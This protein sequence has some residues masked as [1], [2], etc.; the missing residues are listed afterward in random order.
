MNES[1]RPVPAPVFF[2][3]SSVFFLG[4][5]TPG[6]QDGAV[7][8]KE[9]F[10]ME[11]KFKNISDRAFLVH[12]EMTQRLQNMEQRVAALESLIKTY[13]AEFKHVNAKLADLSAG[14]SSQPTT[15]VTNPSMSIEEAAREVDTQLTR[16]KDGLPPDGVAKALAPLARQAAP[17]ICEALKSSLRDIEYMKKLEYVLARLPAAELKISTE[18]ALK[19]RVARYPVARVVGDVGDKELSRVLEPYTSDAE[20][21]FCYL[22]G[23]SLVRCRNRAGVPALLRALRAEDRNTRFLAIATLRPL[24]N[25]ETLG[26]DFNKNADANT[27]AIKAWEEWYDKAGPRLFE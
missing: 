13:D 15:G 25:D 6:G 9:L 20:L 26:F 3:L 1:R 21:D 14:R 17:K 16:L 10:E 19:D 11:T 8:R 7:T 2:L 23:N 22:V 27:A 4:C 18:S 24:N 5:Q 12:T